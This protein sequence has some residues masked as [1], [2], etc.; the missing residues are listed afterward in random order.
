M[1]L[2]SILKVLLMR[3]ECEPHAKSLLLGIKCILKISRK[4]K[5]DPQHAL[6]YFFFGGGENLTTIEQNL[7]DFER[8]SHDIAVLC[9][10]KALFTKLRKRHY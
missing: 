7:K 2:K 4:I 9:Q 1:A 8:K 10:T 5:V 3:I 6:S